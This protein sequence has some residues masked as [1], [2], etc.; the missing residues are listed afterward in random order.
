MVKGES[1]MNNCVNSFF[2]NKSWTKGGSLKTFVH[3]IVPKFTIGQDHKVKYQGQM[4]D[5]LKMNHL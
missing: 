5:P 3:K 1:Q 4:Q 2:G